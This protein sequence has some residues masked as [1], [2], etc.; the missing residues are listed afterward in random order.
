MSQASTREAGLLLALL[1]AEAFQTQTGW[2]VGAG[3]G[4]APFRAPPGGSGGGS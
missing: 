3:R 1:L 4:R 2:R